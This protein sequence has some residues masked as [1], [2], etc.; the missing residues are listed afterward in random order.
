MTL[1]GT[2]KSTSDVMLQGFCWDVTV[3]GERGKLY[4]HLL[5][6][7][8]DFVEAGITL[9]W[10]PPPSK[11]RY[12]HYMGYT[13]MDYYDLGE[14]K[15]WIQ[16]WPVTGQDYWEESK[17]AETRY[18]TRAELGLL[19]NEAHNRGLKVIADLVLNHR[20]A[21]QRNIEGEKLS[22]KGDQYQI[23]SG[24]MA[25]GY[26]QK[27][28]LEIVTGSGGGGR[29]DGQSGFA[30][31]L[32]HTEPQL[33]AQMKEWLSWLKNDIR[34]DGWR[35]DMVKGFAPQHVAEYNYHTKPYLS[36]GEYW[37]NNTQLIYDWVDQTDS[38]DVSQKSMAFDFPL[39]THLRNIF[40]GDKPFDQLGLWKYSGVS[41]TGG[42]SAKSV[43]FL[44]NH[45]TIRQAYSDFPRDHKRLLQ[46]YA[47]LLTHPGI[48]CIYWEHMYSVGSRAHN[49]II[50][51]G[52]FRSEQKITN[53]SH[54]HV[55]K[56]LSDCYVAKIDNT[57]IVK[58]GDSFW[59]P[60]GYPGSW[61]LKLSGDGWAIWT[62][63]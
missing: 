58:I 37:D 33:R 25:W 5:S 59:N 12:Q 43:T 44:E 36:V 22:W 57:T 50:A 61:R 46:G 62:L 17:G 32:A 53:Q 9:I 14:F 21:Q 11:S 28:P 40:W 7:L 51:L 29:D 34:F 52:R 8:P 31:N 49:G 35:Y 30:P 63:D 55:L 2:D 39:Q 23:A 56:A 41:I 3:K 48:P 4:T 13:P 1:Y 20:E 27:D 26:N 47:F 10:L 15:Q 42:W 6:L 18:G 60:S 54:V 19:I 38:F 24:K 16:E 45:D